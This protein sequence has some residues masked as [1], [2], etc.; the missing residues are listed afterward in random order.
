MSRYNIQYKICWLFDH[1]KY[2]NII[3]IY[4]P[5]EDY[6]TKCLILL[7]YKE[8]DL[9]WID[10]IIVQILDQEVRKV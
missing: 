9:S 6:F 7:D 5:F 8:I 1:F 3:Y 10:F 4:P 2:K